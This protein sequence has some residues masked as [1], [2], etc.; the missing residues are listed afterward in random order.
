MLAMWQSNNNA[1]NLYCIPCT[2]LIRNDTPTDLIA[3][4]NSFQTKDSYKM[5]KGI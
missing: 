3:Q 2:T 5:E 1:I 4:N